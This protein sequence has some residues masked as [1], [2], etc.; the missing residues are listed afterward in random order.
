MGG[1]AERESS[2]PGS[3]LVALGSLAVLIGAVVYL[4]G[5]TNPFVYD[6]EL[7]VVGNASIRQLVNWR[8]VLLGHQFRPLTNQTYALD[9]AMWGLRPLG[10]HLTGL[11]LHLVNV[12]LVFR[13][14]LAVVG[15]R[16]R[17]RREPG[18]PSTGATAG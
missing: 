9:Y 14:G 5:L 4:N 1:P 16:R 11:L 2:Q 8:Y 6:D 7:T 12:A 15:D 13:L 17:E 18:A 10:F 3:A